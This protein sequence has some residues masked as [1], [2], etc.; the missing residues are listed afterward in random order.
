MVLFRRISIKVHVGKA[1][2][3]A[4]NFPLVLP[5]KIDTSPRGVGKT[6]RFPV[7]PLVKPLEVI[8]TECGAFVRGLTFS[9]EAS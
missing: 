2:P 8:V 3:R 5:V 4:I 6:K 1:I 7:R 9:T